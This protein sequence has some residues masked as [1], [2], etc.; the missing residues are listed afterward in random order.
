MSPKYILKVWVPTNQK[1]H[2]Y[3]LGYIV[4]QLVEALRYKLEG[5]RVHSQRHFCDF[6]LS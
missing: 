2:F 5:H 3:N 1:G 6:S 4:V